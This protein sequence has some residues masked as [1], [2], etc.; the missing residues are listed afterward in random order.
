M[1]NHEIN[2]HREKHEIYGLIHLEIPYY[3]FF[4]RFLVFFYLFFHKEPPYFKNGRGGF[5]A[6]P[7]KKDELSG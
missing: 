6:P 3:A 7:G 2:D 5:I 4:K 1:I